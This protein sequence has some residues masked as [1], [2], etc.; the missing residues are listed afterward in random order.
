[1]CAGLTLVAVGAV[2]VVVP[3]LPTTVFLLLASYCF[4]RSCP[5]MSRWVREHR[6]LGP[7][8]RQ[9]ADGAGIPPAVKLKVWMF[10]WVGIVIGA[11]AGRGLGAAFVLVLVTLGLI[12]TAAVQ[13]FSHPDR[14]RAFVRRALGD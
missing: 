8:V 10:I 14:V 9:V 7:Y 6:V 13:H 4:L 1:M 2:G 3:G 12:G 5:A 11:V